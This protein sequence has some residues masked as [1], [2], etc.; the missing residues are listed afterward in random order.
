MFYDVIPISPFL[1]IPFIPFIPSPNY[2]IVV[3]PTWALLVWTLGLCW[4]VRPGF[5]LAFPWVFLCC[6]LYVRACRP[7]T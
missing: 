5:S 2:V 1:H 7:I 6:T 3:A 4:T